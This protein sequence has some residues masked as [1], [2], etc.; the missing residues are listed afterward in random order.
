MTTEQTS[1]A[2][3]ETASSMFYDGNEE[4][5][6]EAKAN[7]ETSEE[8]KEA[9]SEK[10]DTQGETEAKDDSKNKDNDEEVELELSLEGTK[11][12]KED[13]V[14]EV[15]SFAKEHGL[16]KEVAQGILGQRE[17]LI[18]S[19]VDNFVQSELKEL[20]Q[21]ETELKNDKVLGGDNL[22]TTLENS[23][24]AFTSHEAGKEALKIL[25]EHRVVSHPKVVAWLNE[26]GKLY[27][28]SDFLNGSQEPAQQKASEILYGEYKRN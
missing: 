1:E 2:T 3:Q 24:L 26:V 18:N 25:D 11:Y 7:E 15:A 23:K 27:K 8:T 19:V 17:N 5:V 21:W 12:L 6:D 9:N 16:S 20:E 4:R 10:V 28:D 22:S 13:D 14:Q